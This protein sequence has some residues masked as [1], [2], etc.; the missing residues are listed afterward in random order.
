MHL[1]NQ[2]N[3]FYGSVP[4]VAGTVPL[5]VGAGLAA[6]LCKSDD[7]GVAYLGDG[8]IEEGVVSE[9]LNLAS[10]LS[11]PVLFVVENNLFSSH[12]HI[13]ER[14]PNAS[15]CRFAEANDIEF[16]LVDGNDICEVLEVSSR[17]IGN[18]RSTKKPA[19]IEAVTYRH[20]GHVDWRDDIDVGVNRSADDLV[21]WKQRDPIKRLKDSL[22][23]NDLITNRNFDE[24]Y[25]E[26][27][28]QAE[29]EWDRAH[30]ADFPEKIF[31]G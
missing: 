13:S 19:F 8:A 11:I 17:L 7:I 2:P 26:I 10:L 31:I 29:A 9:S 4:I 28:S 14:Q 22:I 23:K 15:T 3:G 5:A 16:E 1:W 25:K 20:Y 30:S 27:I 24:L 21:K 18:V 6:K 12:M